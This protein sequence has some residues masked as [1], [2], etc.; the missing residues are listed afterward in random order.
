MRGT[1]YNSCRGKHLLCRQQPCFAECGDSFCLGARG[2]C[3][4]LSFDCCLVC[5]FRPCVNLLLLSPDLLPRVQE[6][7]VVLHV[8]WLK[9]GG[10]TGG[11]LYQFE[12]HGSSS[13][14]DGWREVR[15]V[16]VEDECGGCRACVWLYD[17]S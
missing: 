1:I 5:V 14:A 4:R 9:D 2:I 16:R 12:I 8:E 11:D 15:C 17:F 3:K 13:D 7:A 6:G 10:G